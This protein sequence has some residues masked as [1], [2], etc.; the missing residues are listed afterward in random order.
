M[1]LSNMTELCLTKIDLFDGKLGFQINL[2]TFKRGS[3][4]REK[5]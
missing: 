5:A 1:Q 3:Q 2:K 4:Y